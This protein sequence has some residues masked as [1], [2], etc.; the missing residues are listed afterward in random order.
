MIN[1]REIFAYDR[2]GEQECERV[3]L[4]VSECEQYILEEGDLLFARQ[5]LTYDGAGKCALV[6]HSA[7]PRTWDSHIMRA[8]IARE[9]ADPD[10]YYYYFR[11]P[12]GRRN[13]ETIVQQVAAAGIRGSDLARLV[14][15]KPPRS[16]QRAIAGV[17]RSLDDKI[18]G[19]DRAALAATQLMIAL[20]GTAER[21]VVVASLARHS[22][23]VRQPEQF[24]EVVAYYSLPAFDASSGPATT[25]RTEIKSNKL[26]L[27]EPVVLVSKLNPRIPRIWNV[28]RTPQDMAV[29]STEFVVLVPSVVSTST[30]WAALSQP[31]VSVELANKVSGTSGSHQR[32]KPV[33]ILELMVPDP[34]DLPDKVRYEID[35]LGDVVDSLQTECQ[36][37]VATRDELL[38]LLMSGKVCVRDAERVVSEVV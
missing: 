37:L 9:V 24:D 3:P 31:S 16:T 4:T 25:V 26:V 14:V 19:N 18:A 12:I 6:L 7:E 10:Y 15:P 32:V 11:S 21:R 5:S 17:L 30:L 36:R 2:I 20:A 8:R 29:A 1:M 13:I 28:S 35:A 27:D 23:R 38:P 33:D 22:T 34:R